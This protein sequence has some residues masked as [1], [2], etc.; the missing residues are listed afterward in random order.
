MW[1]GNTLINWFLVWI[2]FNSL[3]WKICWQDIF[4][5]NELICFLQYFIHQGSNTLLRSYVEVVNFIL[6]EV[7]PPKPTPKRKLL[8]SYEP[9]SYISHKSFTCKDYN[10]YI[11]LVHF[12]SLYMCN[13]CSDPFQAYK[14][15]RIIRESYH[16]SE[17]EVREFFRSSYENL[18]NYKGGN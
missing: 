18:L 2:W 1:S 17:E 11:F 13:V 9:V 15:C 8:E 6:H 16:I 10:S 14:S 12:C 4:S 7:Y 5:K 3:L